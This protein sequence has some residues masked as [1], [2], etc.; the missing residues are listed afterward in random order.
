L[1]IH[2]SRNFS[3]IGLSNGWIFA[4]R[5]D[6]Y[7]GLRSQYPYRWQIAD[8]EDR[9][10]ELIVDGVHNIWICELGRRDDDGS[11]EDFVD[12][13]ATALI[14]WTDNAV[15]Y[16]SPSQ[17][18]LEWG[19]RGALRRNGAA[20]GPAPGA[21][22]DNSFVQAPFPAEQIHVEA[23]GHRLELDWRDGT[24]TKEGARGLITDPLGPRSL[25]S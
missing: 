24:R 9:G 20:V 22:Y 4:R 14:A 13:I 25:T 15:V 21:R 12:R 23:K 1:R 16:E 7:L 3:H 19:W 17:G 8:G 10:R 11:F 18:R 5:C 6:G 2:A